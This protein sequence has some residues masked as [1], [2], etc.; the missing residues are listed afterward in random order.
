M[1]CLTATFE[2]V[3][4][5]LTSCHQRVG[6]DLACTIYRM[7][8]EFPGSFDYSFDDSF[9]V[10]VPCS[11]DNSFDFSFASQPMC[12]NIA[13]FSLVPPTIEGVFSRKGGMEC[14][15]G[16]VCRTGIQNFVRVENDWIFLVPEN[17]FTEDNLVYSNVEWNVT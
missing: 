11:F 10:L 8:S 7:P 6:G 16:L 14:S 5:R 12:W 4:G 9:A 1:G 3:G 13:S 17:L 2:M 15:F